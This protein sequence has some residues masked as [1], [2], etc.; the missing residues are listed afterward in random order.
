MSVG[1]TQVSPE[2]VGRATRVRTAREA[3]RLGGWGLA[4]LWFFWAPVWFQS[5]SLSGKNRAGGGGE[6]NGNSE[7]GTGALGRQG[8]SVHDQ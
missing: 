7:E 4:A 1:G 2:Q 5:G 3:E 8:S 6:S